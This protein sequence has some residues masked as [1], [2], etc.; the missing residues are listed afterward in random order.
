[1][2]AKHAQGRAHRDHHEDTPRD[3]ANGGQ[4]AEARS[5]PAE[6]A[7]ASGDECS[8]CDFW[9][10]PPPLPESADEND[11]ALRAARALGELGGMCRFLPQAMR[12][13]ENDWCGQHRRHKSRE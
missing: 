10:A 1:M 4:A 9:L 3:D 8:N 6:T 7:A 11:P 2:A 12:K 5:L 13:Q